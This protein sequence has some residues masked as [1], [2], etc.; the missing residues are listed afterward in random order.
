MKIQLGHNFE[1]IVSLENLLEAWKEFLKG[2]RNKP[3]SKSLSSI[4]LIT[5]YNFIKSLPIR[6]TSMKTIIV[7][8]FQIP[9]HA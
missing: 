1:E 8:I 9:N 2:K 3:T 4:C 7:S 6:A 5:Y